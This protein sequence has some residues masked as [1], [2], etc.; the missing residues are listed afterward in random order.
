ML[1]PAR[2]SAVSRRR[3]RG[4]GDH[5]KA[6]CSLGSLEVLSFETLFVQRHRSNTAPGNKETAMVN[7][8]H[9]SGER[10]R[11]KFWRWVRG[12]C[13]RLVNRRTLVV[14][15]RCLALIVRLVEIFKRLYGDF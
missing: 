11:A 7:R 15:I 3:D 10:K 5:R 4:I 2:A 12:T 14:A 9:S 6:R 1:G 13:R 8:A